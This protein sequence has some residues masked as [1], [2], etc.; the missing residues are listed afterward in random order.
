MIEMKENEF[1]LKGFFIIGLLIIA[2]FSAAF[3]FFPISAG[4]FTYEI[5]NFSSYDDLLLFLKDNY[6][7]YSDWNY[8]EDG[9][10]FSI[11]KTGAPESTNSNTV[12]GGSTDY[13]E[14]NIQ[15]E[16]VDEPDIVKTDGSY[17]YVIANSKLYII[18][19]YPSNDIKIVSEISFSGDTYASNLFINEDR[20]IVFCSVSNYF[21]DDEYK[22]YIDYWWGGSS[23]T[24]IYIYDI[25]DKSNPE[26]INDIEIDGWYF[27][28]RMVDEYVYVIVSEYSY[29][30]YT[31]VDGNESLIIPKITINNESREIPANDIYY[32]DINEPDCVESGYGYIQLKLLKGYGNENKQTLG[33]CWEYA[34][35]QYLNTYKIPSMRWHLHTSQGFVLLGDPSLKIGG[36]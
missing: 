30:I 18:K 6:N 11:S 25:T 27:D 23:S 22:Y 20:L 14:T 19:A 12:D 32:V 16:G 3:I 4:E 29:E 21:Y 17:I 15:V 5:D 28:S 2:S 36:Y 8:Y 24:I 1:K 35:N 10:V 13:S 26:L 34:I 31:V 7:N 9:R 33:E